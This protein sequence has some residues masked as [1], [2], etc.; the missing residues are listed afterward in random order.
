MYDKY[1]IFMYK[2]KYTMN[3]YTINMDIYVRI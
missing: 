2:D 3:M 1:W